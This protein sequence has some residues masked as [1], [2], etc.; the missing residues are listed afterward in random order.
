MVVD[1]VR[2]L[3]PED[4]VLEALAVGGLVG[5]AV[6]DLGGRDRHLRREAGARL[7]RHDQHQVRVRDQLHAE[8]PG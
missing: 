2:R 1:A 5:G 6:L 4:V 3:P 7:V 8:R